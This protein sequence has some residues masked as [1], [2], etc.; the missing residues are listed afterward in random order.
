M[1]AESLIAEARASERRERW[2]HRST[3]RIIGT[4]GFSRPLPKTGEVKRYILTS[5]QNNTKIHEQV[6]DALQ[7]LAKYYQA[8]I[9]VGTFSYDTGAY[10]KKAV[11]RGTWGK[12]G[13]KEPL[14]YDQRIESY[15]VDQRI[16]LAP[17]L[18][19]CGEMNIS[20]TTMNPLAS[21]E[22][23]TAR[24]SAIFP[25]VKLAMRSIPAMLGDAAKLN[26]T[27][28]TVTKMNYIQKRFGLIAEFHH[29]YGALL[30][31]V[32]HEG[33]WWVRQLN[34]D[35][36]GRIQDLDVIAKGSKVTTGNKIEAIT[37]GD[38]HGTFVDEGVMKV[39]L[40]MLD[41]LKPKFQFLHDVLEGASIN[42]HQVKDGNPH[43]N[44]YRWIRGLHRVDE[45][46]KKTAEVLGKYLRPWSKA[47][48]PDANHD[49]WWLKS[50]LARYDYR[51]DPANSEL[52]LDLQRQFYAE[53]RA[54]KMPRDV[55]II[56]YAFEKFGLK[57]V[58]FLLP[59]E[60]FKICGNKI[61]CG[62]H[63]HLGPGGKRGTPENLSKMGRRA[64]IAHTHSAGIYDGLYVAGTS[65]KLK[66]CYNV[67]PS[68]WTHSHIVTYGNAK[69]AIVTVFAGK[70]RA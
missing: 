56:Q 48:A 30:V 67:G 62:M 60:S 28:G 33:Q 58:R 43:Y 38:I 65:S 7:A 57:G 44:F 2:K 18:V 25:H 41:T 29:V 37:W 1:K 9:M 42:R 16:E 24:K 10:G 69:R 21:L 3:G 20:P 55:N 64:N 49:A 31:E 8:E 6:W 27:T 19:W 22:S 47:I 50:W 54:G 52:F 34:A 5:A 46:F 53:I 32:N 45:E 40:E 14:W 68:D 51:V 17:G 23:Y 59:D 66:W 70:W 11:K 12:R 35:R 15:I 36:E 4:H 39:S 63:G 13:E 61:E 26:Y